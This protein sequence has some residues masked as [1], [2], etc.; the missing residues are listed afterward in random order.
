MFILSTKLF[1]SLLDCKVELSYRCAPEVCGGVYSFGANREPRK[2]ILSLSFING[3]I[4]SCCEEDVRNG[5]NGSCSYV[6]YGR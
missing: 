2:E 4:E 6:Q 5:F 3:W 1:P